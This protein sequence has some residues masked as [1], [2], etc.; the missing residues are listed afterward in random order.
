MLT[1]ISNEILKLR[2]V[3]T[4][5]VLLL[6][7]Q[8]LIVLGA[9]G[10]LIRADGDRGAAVGAVA[11]LGLT[12]LIALIFGLM[13][14]AGEYRHRTITDTFL[15]TPRRGRVIA[16]KMSVYTAAGIGFGLVGAII[17][18]AT[19]ASWLAAQGSSLDL[20]ETELWRTIVGGVIWN[21]AFA[22][23]GVSVGALLRNLTAAIA[24]ALA[25]LALVEGLL[26][27]LLGTTL[28]RWLPFAAGSSLG[29]LPAAVA[30]GLPQWGGGVVLVVYAAGLAVIA[31]TTSVRRDIA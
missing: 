30:G 20:G 23:I 2:T 1:L 10:R 6:A 11:H 28:S 5:W 21:A 22:A 25:W 9:S 24:V 17:A 29:R 7:A 14:V 3:R 26:G 15:A 8:A 19:S 27:Q 13:A 16:A 31:V 4:P 12:S 18:L